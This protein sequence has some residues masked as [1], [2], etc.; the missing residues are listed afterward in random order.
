MNKQAATVWTIVIILLTLIVVGIVALVTAPKQ[1]TNG[2]LSL[3]VQADDWTTGGVN[4]SSTVSLVEYSD[5]QCPACAFYDPLVRRA[6]SDIPEL[7]LTYRYFPLTQTHKNADL[8]ARAVEAAG[9]QGRFWE[10]GELLFTNQEKWANDDKAEAIFSGYAQQLGLDLTKFSEDL[11]SQ[12][13][14]DKIAKDYQSGLDSGVTGTPSFYL[15]GKFITNPKSY[16]EFVTL[17]KDAL[18]TS[19]APAL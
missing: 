1:P 14:K 12:A 13:T 19:P 5:F 8:S 7:V 9:Q 6:L 11:N 16:E 17:I 15:N 18:A 10:M 2:I 4:A 3:P